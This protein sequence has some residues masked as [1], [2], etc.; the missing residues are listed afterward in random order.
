[1]K[2]TMKILNKAIE[3]VDSSSLSYLNKAKLKLSVY[4]EYVSQ[5]GRGI[6]VQDM[7]AI[8]NEIAEKIGEDHVPTG[9]E[10]FPPV[11]EVDDLQDLDSKESSGAITFVSAESRYYVKMDGVW[12]VLGR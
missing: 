11:D 5:G 2:P 6:V 1:M 3:I 8:E 10:W 9:L 12:Y 7:A 4:K